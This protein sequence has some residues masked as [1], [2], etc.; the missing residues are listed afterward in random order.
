VEVLTLQ[1]G[2]GYFAGDLSGI[3]AKK[4]PFW[5]SPFY[6]PERRSPGFATGTANLNK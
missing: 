5:F 1:K 6:K 4:A 2:P 3:T